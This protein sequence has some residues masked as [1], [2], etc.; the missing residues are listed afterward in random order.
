MTMMFTDPITKKQQIILY[1]TTNNVMNKN[2]SSQRTIFRPNI[3]ELW[4]N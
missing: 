1:R 3:I 4:D 2:I